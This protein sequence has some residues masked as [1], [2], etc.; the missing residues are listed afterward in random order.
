[1]Q[2]ADDPETSV[3]ATLAPAPAAVEPT[4]E[5]AP[6]EQYEE[7][8]AEAPEAVQPTGPNPAELV[9]RTFVEAVARLAR[10]HRD[11]VREAGG[12]APL[13][14]L[15]RSG[16]S[17]VQGLAAAVLRDLATDNPANR[18]AILNAGGLDELVEMVR[19]DATRPAAGEAAGALRALSSGFPLGCKAIC[20]AG[21]IEALVQMVRC[22][23]AGSNAPIHATGVLANIAQAS[24]ANCEAILRLG[25]V[26]QLVSLFSK[27]LESA[28]R[29]RVAP[30]MKLWLEKACEEAANALWQLAA[31][32][33]SCN[34]AIREAKAI[35]PLIETLLR[36]GLN[37]TTANHSAKVGH[38][39]QHTRPLER[40]RATYA[41]QRHRSIH[42]HPPSALLPIR[43]WW[44]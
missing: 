35:P 43:R 19:S 28:G 20:S 38:C 33:P 5:E 14:T 1:M 36:S 24:E 32:A 10:S 25:G 7:A 29:R 11:A 26:D 30:E 9:I 40:A 41:C 39:S 12:I 3:A 27:D 31:V 13:V 42:A 18:D 6:K 4:A 17:E 23:K 22:G 2:T 21:G 16:S 8:L 37:S 44:S 34:A 15:L